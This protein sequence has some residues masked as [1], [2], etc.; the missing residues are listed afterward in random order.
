VIAQRETPLVDI[1]FHVCQKTL[2]YMLHPGPWA[3]EEG[4]EEEREGGVKGSE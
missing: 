1:I 2:L 3:E 4:E